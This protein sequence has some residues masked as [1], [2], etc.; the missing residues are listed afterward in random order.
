VTQF[1]L[2]AHKVQKSYVSSIYRNNVH[3]IREV[4]FG[5]QNGERLGIVGESGSGKTT[6]C[7]LL[8]RLEK[9]TSGKIFYDN[10]DITDLPEK[11]LDFLRKNVQIIFQNSMNAMNPKHT[12]GAI[13]E[14]PMQIQTKL[15]A[16][17]RY[18]KNQKLL[19]DVGLQQEIYE[20]YPHELSGGQRQRVAIA[21]A[22]SLEPKIL[23]CDEPVTS[24]DV[25]M[26]AQILNLLLDLQQNY[27]LS[28]IF[29]SHDLDVVTAMSTKI[30]VMHSGT[31]CEIISSY[32]IFSKAQHPYTKLLIAT[33]MEFKQTT[34]TNCLEK[35]KVK[36]YSTIKGCTF[37]N[38]CSIHQEQCKMVKPELRE[39]APDHWCACH[40]L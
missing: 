19:Q 18:K 23:I 9:P 10:I 27:N 1:L 22:L 32:E 33:L 11:K 37:Y 21:R 30:A 26:K 35:Q 5:L 28:M 25:S 12:I 39:I 16:S 34:I 13:I 7:K 6:L 3:A 17:D 36:E 14:E 38:Y 4:S 24:L 20:R 15:S 40:L 31:I 8:V 29:V 2:E